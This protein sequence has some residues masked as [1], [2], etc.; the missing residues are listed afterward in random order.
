MSLD[1]NV[2]TVSSISLITGVTSLSASLCW[3]GDALCA[4]RVALSPSQRGLTV[5]EL[6]EADMLARLNMS[7]T[8]N[9]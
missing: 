9:S 2:P 6:S 7:S 5:S 4:S 8:H 1:L 3:F